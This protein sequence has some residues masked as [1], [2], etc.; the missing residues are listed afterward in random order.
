MDPARYKHTLGTFRTAVKLA[1]LYGV[2]EEKAATAA[3]LH[4]AGKSFSKDKMI[5]YARSNKLKVPHFDSVVKH[6]P[7]LLHGYISAHIAEKKFGIK[8]KEILQAITMHT[9]GGKDMCML[10][11]IIYIADATSP[12]RRHKNVKKLRALSLKDIDKAL[13]LAMAHKLFHVVTNDKW[14]HPDAA[15][16]WNSRFK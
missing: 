14:L 11:K 15:H 5:E 7:S 3:L 4:D 1:G 12:D 2:S 16:A 8:D 6:S 9:L 13:K 10:A